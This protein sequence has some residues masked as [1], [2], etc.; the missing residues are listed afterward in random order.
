MDKMINSNKAP[1]GLLHLMLCIF[2]KCIVG[3]FK[4]FTSSLNINAPCGLLQKG[5]KDNHAVKFAN[6]LESDAS[7]S[8]SLEYKTNLLSDWFSFG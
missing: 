8:A 2:R 1:L 7:I 5:F 3:R 6:L 4:V